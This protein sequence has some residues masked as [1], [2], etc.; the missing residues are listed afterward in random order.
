MLFL[1]APTKNV[2]AFTPN[3]GVTT[4]HQ[5][6]RTH[7]PLLKRNSLQTCITSGYHMSHSKTSKPKSLTKS[8]TPATTTDAENATVAVPST[9]PIKNSYLKLTLDELSVATLHQVA[10]VMHQTAIELRNERA[11]PMKTDD[12][13]TDSTTRTTTAIDTT[14]FNTTPTKHSKPLSFRP[15]SL[16]SLHITLFFGGHALAALTRAELLQWHQGVSQLIRATIPN[17]DSTAGVGIKLPRMILKDLTSFPP[18]RNNLI[19]AVLEPSAE[20][21]DLHDAILDFTLRFCKDDDGDKDEKDN[22]SGAGKALLRQVCRKNRRRWT[23]HVTLGNLSGLKRTRKGKDGDGGNDDYDSFDN[24][25]TV[26]AAGRQELQR[27][28]LNDGGGEEFEMVSRGVS[29]GGPLPCGCD[30]ND[31]DGGGDGGGGGELDWDLRF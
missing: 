25:E 16:L 3:L 9:E 14:N 7:K 24:L 4:L 23:P 19:V 1:M 6:L 17:D 26:L 27:H 12:I 21:R 31:L 18:R 5:K 29:M 2:V 13:M 20:L 22:G 10:L 15:R 30:Y 28:I 8:G 11:E